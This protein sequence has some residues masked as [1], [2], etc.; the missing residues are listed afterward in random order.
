VPQHEVRCDPRESKFP[1]APAVPTQR[2]RERLSTGLAAL[3]DPTR[4]LV[5]QHTLSTSRSVCDIAMG[6]PVSRPAVSQHLR[7]LKAAGLVTSRRDGPRRLYTAD[8]RAVG[9]VISVL[10]RM[11]RNATAARASV[12]Q[13]AKSGRFHC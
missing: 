1:Y 8:L 10:E 7:V 4:W 5:F 3:A 9:D 2:A 13:E 11:R 6:L 12:G